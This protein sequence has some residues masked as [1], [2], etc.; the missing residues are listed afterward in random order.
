MSFPLHTENEHVHTAEVHAQVPPPQLWSSFGER[1]WRFKCTW[2][3]EI[4]HVGTETP[5]VERR[6]KLKKL[7]G[8]LL[9][10]LQ[11]N[12]STKNKSIKAKIVRHCALSELQAFSVRY[13]VDQMIH[14]I[15]HNGR[16]LMHC[17]YTIGCKQRYPSAKTS[18]K[19]AKNGTP[20]ARVTIDQRSKQHD[21]PHE[22]LSQ[23][24]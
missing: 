9:M 10:A 21:Q 5:N 11:S 17:T 18:L 2:F 20:S 6:L 12:E 15:I 1:P 14:L 23:T 4:S 8:T 7:S 16:W 19:L 3:G 13:T 24:G 22:T